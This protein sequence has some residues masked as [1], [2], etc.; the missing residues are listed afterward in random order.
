MTFRDLNA[1]VDVCTGTA[2][3]ASSTGVAGPQ[4]SAERRCVIC[5]D[6]E[7]THL[8]LP[9]G[10]KCLCAAC[11][12]VRLWSCPVCRGHALRVVRVYE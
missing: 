7:K 12:R 4:V 6:A 2:T 3:G 1:H 8:I 10:H 11:A 9:C 5:L